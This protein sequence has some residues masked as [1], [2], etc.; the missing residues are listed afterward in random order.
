[1]QNVKNIKHSQPTPAALGFK[2]NV[3]HRGDEIGKLP[4][5]AKNL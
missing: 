2:R 4:L 3:A 5:E 1:M